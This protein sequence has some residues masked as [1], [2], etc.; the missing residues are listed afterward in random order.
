MTHSKILAEFAY[1]KDK[2][3]RAEAFVSNVIQHLAMARI[4][5]QL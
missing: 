5:R 3:P 1:K 2:I 4:E